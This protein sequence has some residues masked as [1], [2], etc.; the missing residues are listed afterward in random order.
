MVCMVPHVDA[1]S[2][3]LES[4]VELAVCFLARPYAACR[5]HETALLRTFEKGVAHGMTSGADGNRRRMTFLVLIVRT[6][7]HHAI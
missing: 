3:A 2:R 6:V 5:V 4:L 1:G 7:G